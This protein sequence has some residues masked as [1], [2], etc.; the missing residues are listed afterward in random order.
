MLPPGA[1]VEQWLVTIVQEFGAPVGIAFDSTSLAQV[2]SSITALAQL[3]DADPGVQAVY[4]DAD[5]TPSPP[6]PPSP[7]APPLSP[8]LPAA[9]VF[10]QV[11]T[12]TVTLG[13]VLDEL[14]EYFGTCVHAA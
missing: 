6:P 2:V 10:E 4:R 5:P 1:E 14:K 9:T 11:D 12:K 3:T 7:L 13:G 8:M